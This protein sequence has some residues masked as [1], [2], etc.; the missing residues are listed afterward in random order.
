MN[1]NEKAL[2]LIE[3]LPYIQK[4]KN[5]VVVIKFGGNALSKMRCLAEDI[6]LLNHIGLKPVIIHGGGPEISLEMKKAGI[7]PKFVN[8]LRYTDEATIKI[9]ERVF[10]KINNEIVCQINSLG[11]KSVN[12][13]HC[14]K[15]KQKSKKLGLVGDITGIDA[16]KIFKIINS[17]FIPVISPLG[18]GSDKKLYN[19][20][21]DIAASRIA[22]AVN[23]EKLAIITDVDGVMIDGQL[24][25][26]LDFKTAQK[27]IQNGAISKGMIP[28][29]EAGIYA[30]KNKCPKVH[31]I[32]GLIP[33]SLLLE[34]FTDKGIGTEIVYKK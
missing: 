24:L 2:V 33:H 19:I 3:S 31:L 32:N 9:A 26:H 12:A 21:A 30:V 28:K 16:D 15:S 8:G 20:N 6:V 5:G 13:Y 1:L 4:Y 14:I 27:G 29:V 23:A 17:G 34:I 10:K 18:V 22:V 11:S 25:P 7:E